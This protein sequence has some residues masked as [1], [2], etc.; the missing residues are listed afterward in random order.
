MND[1]Q[2]AAVTERHKGRESAGTLTAA[3]E[4]PV[5]PDDL[6]PIGRR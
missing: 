6:L 3:F 4:E 5:P 1:S 2:I